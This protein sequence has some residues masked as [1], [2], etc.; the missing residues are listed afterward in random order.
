VFVDSPSQTKVVSIA[1]EVKGSQ[2]SII[3]L[4][5][6][7]SLFTLAITGVCI[8]FT[9]MRKTQ[10][11]LDVELTINRVQKEIHAKNN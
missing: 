4:V 7:L 2:T 9:L 5:A 11:K 3:I 8:R 10:E 6:V 1:K